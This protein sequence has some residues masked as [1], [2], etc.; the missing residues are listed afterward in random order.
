MKAAF[1]HV[2]DGLS[3]NAGYL[4]DAALLPQAVTVRFGGDR[5]WPV[6]GITINPQTPGVWPPE[7]MA[8]FELLLST[9]GAKFER[10]LT[11]EVSQQ[12]SEQS[13]VLP[14]AIY[15]KAAQLRILSN[16]DGN[17][18]RVAVSEWKVIVDP[19]VGIGT[20]LDIADLLRGGH[21]VWLIG[22][23]GG[24]AG[25]KRDARG[26]RRW[27]CGF[28]ACK[29]HAAGYDRVSRSRR[30]DHEAG[31]DRVQPA[32]GAVT[33]PAVMIDAS[34]ETPLGPWTR[35]GEW[36]LGGGTLTKTFEK[37]IWARFLRFTSTRVA[38][39]GGET[40]QFPTSCACWSGRATRITDRFWASGDNTWPRASTKKRCRCRQWPNPK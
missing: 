8:N 35:V 12:P 25:R 4:F 5:T 31:L 29:R 26:R 2:N 21:V 10:V 34:T 28:G 40:L 6:R 3:S 22:H 39:E 15:A 20:E 32:N 30:T 14:K 11:G 13:F 33:F 1:R 23:L 16:H 24:N 7:Y 37:P 17:L 36:K 9:D 19:Q 27:P 18:G 38:G